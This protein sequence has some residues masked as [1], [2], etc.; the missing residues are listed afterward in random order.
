M[1]RGCSLCPAWATAAE[2]V[3]SEHVKAVLIIHTGPS[4]HS[5]S[6]VGFLPVELAGAKYKL[7][8]ARGAAVECETKMS[9]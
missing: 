8:K 5:L 9:V 7:H 2:R 4:S 3:K 1:E 6:A